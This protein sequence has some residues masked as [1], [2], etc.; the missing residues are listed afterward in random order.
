MRARAAP[1]HV[2][3][4]EP[5]ARKT[6]RPLVDPVPERDHL[7]DRADEVRRRAPK[8]DLALASTL[9]RDVHGALRQVAK[10]AVHELRA[11]AAGAPGQVAALDES[12]AQ[13]AGG[14][15]EGD[16]R[17]DHAATHHEHVER[18][19]VAKLF[20]VRAALRGVQATVALAEVM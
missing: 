20:E 16:P 1:Q 6:L 15:I 4:G 9:E 3:Q 2:S 13:A 12:H 5:H 7:R 11:P 10:A 14:G 18:W 19:S 17:A 8:Q